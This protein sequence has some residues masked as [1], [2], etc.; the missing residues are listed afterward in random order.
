MPRLESMSPA[1]PRA[2]PT[3]TRSRYRV[4]LLE[5]QRGHLLMHHVLN[6]GF[7]T[8]SPIAHFGSHSSPSSVRWSSSLPV[9]LV[10]CSSLHTCHS[11]PYYSS[12]MALLRPSL[13]FCW[14]SMRAPPSSTLCL[15]TTSFKM[16]F[17]MC[18]M[19]HSLPVEIPKS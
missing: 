13:R 11:S 19:V 5:P 18:L 12:S 8:S 3:S 1:L 14:F 9:S 7:S 2:D 10:A 16:P 6:R 4:S 15:A 17:S